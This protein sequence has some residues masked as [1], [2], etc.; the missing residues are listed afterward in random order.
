MA[1]ASIKVLLVEDNPDDAFILRELI[2]ESATLRFDLVHVER[3]AAARHQLAEQSFDVVLLDL[4]LPDAQ[5]MEAIAEV[6]SSTDTTPIVVLTGRADEELA[7]D[8]LRRGVQD[9]L[10]KINLD[11][12]AVVRAMRYAIERKRQE[13]QQLALGQLREEVW[14]MERAADLDNVLLAVK[15]GLE[16]LDIPFDH[17][18]INVVD[19]RG[20]SPTVR[21]YSATTGGKWLEAAAA[22]AALV[23]KIWSQGFPL[24]RSDLK[25]ID[26]LDEAAHIAA[27][28]DPTVRS[29]LDVPFSHGTL[30]L[31]SIL[32]DAFSEVDI[33]LVQGLAVVLSEGFRRRDDLQ[34]LVASEER[35]RSLVETPHFG[36]M[37][38]DEKGFVYVS[39]NIE[40]LTDYAPEEFYADP[41]L[42]FRITPP[43]DHCIGRQTF[44]RALR[45]RPSLNREFRI[46]RRGGEITWASASTFPLRDSEGTV[47]AVQ[48]VIQD[49]TQRRQ[50]EEEVRQAREEAE[51]ANRAKSEFLANMSHEI[52]TPMNAVIGMST[53][54]AAEDL[55][56]TQRKYLE[57][58]QVSSHS[59]LELLNDVLDLSKIEAGK[60][61]LEL[62]EFALGPALEDVLKPQE[63]YAQEK[64]LEFTY[65]LAP[66]IPDMVIGDSLRLRQILVNLASNAIK[67]TEVGGVAVQVEVGARDEEEVE[68]HFSVYDTGIGVP[69][70]KREQIFEGFTQV[71]TSTTRQ[72][73]G[74]GLGLAISAQLIGMMEG[75]IW[76][77]DAKTEGSVFR[78][79][80]RLGVGQNRVEAAAEPEA[81]EL[82]A[83]DEDIVDCHVLLVEDNRFNQM[84]ARELLERRGYTVSVADHGRAALEALEDLVFDLI[85]MDVQMPEMDGL[86]A[87]G[88]IRSLEQ[89]TGGHIPIVGLTAHALPGDRERCLAAGMDDYV[90]KPIQPLELFAAIA[91]LTTQKGTPAAVQG[92]QI[93]AADFDRAAVL[94]YLE[95]DAALVSRMV[96]LFFEDYP[97]CLGQVRQA[98]EQGDAEALRRASHS[99][100]TPVATMGLGKALERVQELEHLG[101]SG[102]LMSA[103]DVYA[104]LEDEV[105]RLKPALIAFGNGL[106]TVDG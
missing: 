48:V 50:A 11:G 103:R 7:I 24:Y 102:D 38:M 97:K 31:K 14:K 76:V 66:D 88:A 78:F 61:E 56:S 41:Q 62:T 2:D 43:E 101:S 89:Q 93:S 82:L 81:A 99:I 8:V 64:G 96:E 1:G 83:S 21:A 25:E 10:V 29:V 79:I 20:E 12:E 19:D 42:G 13:I 63:L 65:D 59:L 28:Y 69:A 90:T 44:V 26:Q 4:S 75:R 104:A 94:D 3:V 15:T 30:A 33:A 91:A 6:Q 70:D 23:E 9:Y 57:A 74:T 105:E 55:T 39:P 71:D 84:L 92:E 22:E 40:D 52:R 49:I 68:L 95:G 85:L 98:I 34:R 73:G 72:Y 51:K 5:G 27:I 77:E 60:L 32:P 35:F 80:V 53:L 87:T 67:F 37:L 17:C 100:K 18:G 45:G 16:M 54:L 106:H 46:V 86:E 36:V 47:N 58:V